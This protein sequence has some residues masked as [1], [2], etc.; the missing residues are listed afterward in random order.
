MTEKTQRQK[1][2]VVSH[3]TSAVRE[4]KGNECR[5]SAHIVTLTQCGT[6]A[7]EM[8]HSHLGCF[9][10]PQSIQPRKSLT[11]LAEVRIH[12]DSQSH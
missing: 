9:S 3:T 5:C 6:P 8:C 11:E 2:E 4:Q 12:G 1:H 10:L 7:C